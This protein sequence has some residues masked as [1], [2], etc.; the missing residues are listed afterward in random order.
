MIEEIIRLAIS[1]GLW[2]AL[3]CLL[4]IY[5]LKDSSSREKKYVATIDSLS[6]GLK[7]TEQTAAECRLIR[8]D[9]KEIKEDCK[10]FVFAERERLK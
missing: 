10:N 1:N 4:F 8:E 5:Q 3:F 6:Q 7:G 9:L 2:A